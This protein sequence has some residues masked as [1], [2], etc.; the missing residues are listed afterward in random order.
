MDFDRRNFIAGAALAAGLAS[1]HGAQAKSRGNGGKAEAKALK[2]LEA[3]VE[4]HRAEW[5]LPGMSVAVVTRDGFEGFVTSGLADVDKKIP[6]GPDH[7]FQIGSISKMFTALAAYSL[8]DEGKLATDVRLHD[9]LKGV[10]VRDGQAITLQHLLNHTAGL[11]ADS[12]IF[13][14]GGLW[15]AFEPGSNWSYSNCGYDLAGMIVAAADGRSNGEAVRARVFNKLGMANARPELRVADRHLYAQG[16]E[17]ALTDRL[18]R[19]PARMTATPWVDSDSAAG[20]IAATPADMAAFMR[21]LIELAGG[22]GGAVFSDETARRFLADPADGWGPGSAYGNGVARVEIDGRN[23]LHHTGGM[24]SFCS[25]LHVDREAGVAAFASSNVHYALGYRPRLVTTFACELLRAIREGASAPEPKP[26]RD[27]LEN[28]QRYA[29][30]YTAPDGTAFE[31]V[32]GGDGIQMRR[33]GAL[34]PMQEAAP[35]LFTSEEAQFAVTGIAFD[36]DGETSARAWAGDVEYSRDPASGY[37]PPADERL[38]A[39][40]GRYD[41][42]NRWAGPL[43]I[44]ARDGA[45]WIGNAVKLKEVAENEFHIDGEPSPERITFGGFINARPQQMWYSGAPYIR[46]FS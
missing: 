23:Y 41:N 22:K 28:P 17:A 26:A 27:R 18:N 2:A 20:C 42:D 43:Y 21:F 46:R 33:G 19:I 8:A 34:S 4:T 32:A 12:D 7:L 45:L 15:S 1:A 37:R 13:P 39:L 14:K 40:A 3:Y 9:A 35:G 31:I 30:V 16:Y 25:S 10:K 29:G 36:M 5:G 11:P 6:V 38:R 24:V 44:Y